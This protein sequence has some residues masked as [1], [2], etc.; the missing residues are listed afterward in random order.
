MEKVITAIDLGTTKFFGLTGVVKKSDISP[1]VEPNIEIKGV[2]I[3][4]TEENWIKGGRIG[5]IEGVVS[6]LIDILDSLRKQSREKI[7]WINVGVGGGHI[8][9]KIYSKKIEI[10]PKGRQINKGDIQILER[11]MKNIIMPELEGNRDIIFIIP[12]EYIIDDNYGV[13]IE[14][15]PIGM[16]GD[17]L[18]MR[19]HIL[20]GEI[21]PIKDI[22]KCADMAGVNVEPNIFPYSWAVAEA[23][24]NEE[25]KKMGCIL[26][27]IGKSTTDFVFYSEGKII[28]TESLQIGS[29][30]IDSD[31]SLIF[32]TS[33]DLAEELK[34]KYTRCDYKD[35]LEARREEVRK[36]E[37]YNPSGKLIRKVGIDEIS[38][39][40]YLRMKEIFEL[41]WQLIQKKAMKTG[42]IPIKI[43][44]VVIS[45]GGA[46]LEGIEKLAEEIFQ[47]PARIGIPQKI[48]NLDKNYQKPEFAA[49]IGLLLIASKL[50]KEE[51]KNIFKKIKRWLSELFQFS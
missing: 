19:A 2:E 33:L 1:D 15:L 14:N 30:L 25:E 32:H 3:I 26:I 39:V 47:L 8:K 43:S 34:K 38:N 27:D 12:Q 18:E 40:V 41:I 7:E 6:G 23:V 5:N 13:P 35:L 36:V 22:Y 4:Q 51:D 49:G 37:I 11:E 29:Y 42:K 46:K 10:V 21:N 48:F 9:G 28:L 31:I 20:T 44:E 17:T 16:H 45:G 24:L 50:V